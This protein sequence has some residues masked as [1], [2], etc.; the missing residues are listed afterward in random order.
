MAEV[1][2]YTD[3]LT[4]TDLQKVESYLALKY[5]ITL[6]QS[7]P[8]QDYLASDGTTKVWDTS[9]VGTVSVLYDVSVATHASSDFDVSGQST[10]P[11]GVVFNNDGSKMYVSDYNAAPAEIVEFNFVIN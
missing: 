5:G 4:G 6:D 8:G 10:T 3:D 9:K 2:A 1:I 11:T 7:A